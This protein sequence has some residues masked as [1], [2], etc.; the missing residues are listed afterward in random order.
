MSIGYHSLELAEQKR[1]ELE[2]SGN[3]N[4]NHFGIIH[5][6]GLTQYQVVNLDKNAAGYS[7]AICNN[8]PVGKP[9]PNWILLPQS[10]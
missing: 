5:P 6:E 4:G 7:C 9:F 10:A 2:T 8:Q 3:P 1:R